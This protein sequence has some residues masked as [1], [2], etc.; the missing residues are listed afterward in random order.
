M[1]RADL[2]LFLASAALAALCVGLIVFAAVV[3]VDS[4]RD[5]RPAAWRLSM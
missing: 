3:Y 4:T 2:T 1:M 5:C